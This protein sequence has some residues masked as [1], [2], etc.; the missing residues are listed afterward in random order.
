[1][2]EVRKEASVAGFRCLD[3]RPVELER[4]I[5]LNPLVDML[6]DPS[7]APH[8]RGLGEPWRAV[9][10]SL[11]P[12]LPAGMDP[13]VVPPIAETSLSRRLYDAFATLLQHGIQGAL[14]LGVGC[15][16]IAGEANLA[17][18]VARRELGIQG[19]RQ[20]SQFVLKGGTRWKMLEVAP[21]TLAAL[22]DPVFNSQVVDSGYHVGVLDLSGTEDSN[23][24]WTTVNGINNL[25][26][27]LIWS[28]PGTD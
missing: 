11:L 13:P 23:Q 26:K 21:K 14:E 4:R 20:E 16:I 15:C 17:V 22:F 24:R 28:I 2:E 25:V 27:P 3:A 9:I 6:A 10:A 19:T 12:T 18:H 7:V 8:I 5:P 1:M